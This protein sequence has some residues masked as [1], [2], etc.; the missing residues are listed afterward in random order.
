[1]SRDPGAAALDPGL[2]AQVLLDAEA[3]R[4]PAGD[5]DLEAVRTAILLEDSLGIV[6]TDADIAPEVLG[7]PDAL[8]RLV[9]RRGRA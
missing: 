2:V 9:E 3:L 6:L 5:P 7:D 4:D 1:V 8:A